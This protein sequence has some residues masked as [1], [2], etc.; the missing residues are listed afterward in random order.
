MARLCLFRPSRVLLNYHINAPI[1]SAL[2]QHLRHTRRTPEIVHVTDKTGEEHT[3]TWKS[4][5]EYQ[6]EQR[7]LRDSDTNVVTVRM[8]KVPAFPRYLYQFRLLLK[9]M[10]LEDAE[11]HLRFNAYEQTSEVFLAMVHRAKEK[12]QVEKGW[13]PANVRFVDIRYVQTANEKS[14]EFHAKGYHSWYKTRYHSIIGHFVEDIYTR[15][16]MEQRIEMDKQRFGRTGGAAD[17]LD[18]PSIGLDGI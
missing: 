6:D 8:A 9:G 2:D 15:Q 3:M 10:M 1:P 17:A 18:V 5:V 4:F 14:V 11:A 7:R 16:R 13:N 12:C